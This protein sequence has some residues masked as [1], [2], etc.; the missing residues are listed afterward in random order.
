MLLRWFRRRHF[1]RETWFKTVIVV[2]G[3]AFGTRL[4]LRITLL[5]MAFRNGLCKLSM[6]TDIDESEIILS[7]R[8]RLIE[9]KQLKCYTNEVAS[10]I[11]KL[12]LLNCNWCRIDHPSQRQHV[13]LMMEAEEKMWVYFDCTLDA[14]SEATIVEVFINSLQ[15]IKPLVN[16]LEL[17]KYTCQDWRTLF[18]VK[19]RELLK[20]QTLAILY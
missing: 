17:L 16:G 4:Y 9:E 8:Q 12:V 6:P 18:C 20:R 14:V 13:S 10:E 3:K 11:C 15:D 1:K 2:L 7:H 5:K 19:N